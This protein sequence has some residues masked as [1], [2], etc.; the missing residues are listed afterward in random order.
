VPSH[1]ISPV[2]RLFAAA[3]FFEGL[4]WAGLL[5][6]MLLKYGTQTTE[7]G[8]WLFG[9]LHGVAF[10]VYL[11][12]SVIAAVRLRWPW[13]AWLLSLLAALP[14]LVTVPLEMW[15]RRIGLLGLPRHGVVR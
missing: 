13:W 3:A 2:G 11:V 8:V 9:R 6:G 4:T 5:L 10:L 1:P 7:L 15:F 14:P 12:A